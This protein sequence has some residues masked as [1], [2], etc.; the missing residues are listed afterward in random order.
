M[1]EPGLIPEMCINCRHRQSIRCARSYETF[2]NFTTGDKWKQLDKC[3][4]VFTNCTHR[5]DKECE[6]I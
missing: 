5:E 1:T 4:D 6:N 2:H 3:I